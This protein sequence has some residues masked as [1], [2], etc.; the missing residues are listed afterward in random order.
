MENLRLLR[1][2]SKKDL[3]I[4]CQLSLPTIN[5][6][7]GN[8]GTIKNHFKVLNALD[9]ELHSDTFHITNNL[10]NN[11][12]T[13][14]Q[15]A[16]MSQDELSKILG[17]TQAT[18]SAIEA[19]KNCKVET[20]FKIIEALKHKVIIRPKEHRSSFIN[21]ARS[22]KDVVWLSPDNIVNAVHTVFGYIDIDPCSETSIQCNTR[23]KV[24][25]TFDDNGLT[26]D[27][28]GIVYI[29]PPFGLKNGMGDFIDKAYKHH[30]QGDT[31]ACILLLPARFELKWFTNLI[32]NRKP[33]L[34]ILR[35]RTFFKG[36]KTGAP[37]ATMIVVWSNLKYDKER[38]SKLLDGWY[39]ETY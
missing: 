9:G 5:K 4:K 10:G 33:D 14:R 17:I 21:M 37:F 34:Y 18:L 31:S 20:I 27:W 13:I 2:I 15:K 6:I 25:Y 23:A 24:A 7:L 8:S 30:E 39:K 38:F 22:N 1:H 28:S 26:R 36:S 12:K 16:K 29:N 3:A 19:N 11:L 35:G 32:E